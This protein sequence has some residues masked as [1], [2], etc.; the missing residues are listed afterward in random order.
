MNFKEF[1]KEKEN[2][3]IIK[4]RKKSR[5]IP[6]DI[7]MKE[8]KKILK[9]RLTNDK[10]CSIINIVLRKETTKYCGIV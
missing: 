10:S 8:F 1:L 7:V 3:K 6:D 2:K 5:I 4:T 9:K